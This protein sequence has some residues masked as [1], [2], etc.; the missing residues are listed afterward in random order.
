MVGFAG[1]TTVFG[2]MNKIDN[3]KILPGEGIGFRY[4]YLKETN[5]KVGFDIAKG[6]GDFNFR[7]SEVF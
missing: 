6:D 3:V 2:S 5:S 1:V 7:L 4:T